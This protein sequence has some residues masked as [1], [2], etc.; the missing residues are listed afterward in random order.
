MLKNT[1]LSWFWNEPKL[2]EFL[3]CLCLWG[4]HCPTIWPACFKKKSPSRWPVLLWF[5]VWLPSL[6]RAVMALTEASSIS[7]PLYKASAGKGK[8]T[9]WTLSQGINLF[10]LGASSNWAHMMGMGRLTD[11]K[12]ANFSLQWFWSLVA[13]SQLFGFRTTPEKKGT[14]ERLYSQ[15]K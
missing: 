15:S 2:L 8:L 1:V 11:G 3:I 9:G 13:A 5:C 4:H 10:R 12:L 14:A 6:Q 7:Q